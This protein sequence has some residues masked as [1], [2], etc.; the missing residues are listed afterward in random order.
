MRPVNLLIAESPKETGVVLCGRSGFFDTPAERDSTLGLRNGFK[1]VFVRPF[2]ERQ[3]SQLLRARSVGSSSVPSWLPRRPLLLT[4]LISRGYT[5][6]MRSNGQN[7]GRGSAWIELLDMICQREAHQCLSLD[8]ETTRL[9]FER[10]ATRSR[11]VLGSATLNI[12]AIATV[13]KGIT[14]RE[15]I[16]DDWQLILRLPGLGPVQ[17]GDSS[18]A[19][20][21]EDLCAAAAAGDL[22]RFIELPFSSEE[23]VHLREVG[24]PLNQ[25]GQEVLSEHLAAVGRLSEGALSIAIDL[26]SKQKLNQTAADIYVALATNGFPYVGSGADIIDAHFD[27]LDMSALPDKSSSIGLFSS[28]IRSAYLPREADVGK[29]PVF[30]ECWFGNVV[31]R[32]NESDLPDDRFRGCMFDRIMIALPSKMSPALEY[33]VALR[34]LVASLEKLFFQAGSGRLEGAFSRGLDERVSLIV[35]DVLKLIDGHGFASPTRI[36]GR[37]VWIPHREYTSRAG[38]IVNEPSICKDPLVAACL[39]IG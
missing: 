2:E 6:D 12:S 10:L 9:F 28:V 4:Y 16:E 8:A 14:K 26:A 23:N 24:A 39:S 38:E 35:P 32:F 34:A 29:L 36:R 31:G 21:D 11:Y 33:P 15:P 20:I 1:T 37:T 18:R 3:V 22:R 7:R 13:F 17:A 5:N 25:L 30:T 27:D 19:F